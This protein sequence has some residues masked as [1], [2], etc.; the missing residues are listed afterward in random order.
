MA[1]AVIN[2]KIVY[3][4]LF[5]GDGAAEHAARFAE[6]MEA[7]ECAASIRHPRRDGAPVAVEVQGRWKNPVTGTGYLAPLVTEYGGSFD[8]TDSAGPES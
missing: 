3:I 7:I 8:G 5:D 2:K 6:G 4:F 1:N